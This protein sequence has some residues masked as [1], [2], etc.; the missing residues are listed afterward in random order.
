MKKTLFLLAFILPVCSVLVAQ[1]P[2]PVVPAASDQNYY[3]ILSTGNNN[4]ATV[5]QQNPDNW[6]RI[7]QPGSGN[8]ATVKQINY[9]TDVDNVIGKVYQEGNNNKARITQEYDGTLG[10][11]GVMEARI[12]QT[13]NGN[14][15][16][17]EQGPG[18]KTGE[19]LAVTNQSG[20]GN[21]GHQEQHG[22]YNNEF[23]LQEGNSNVGRQLQEN[24][25][26]GSNTVIL[27]PGS[28]NKAYQNQTGSGTALNAFTLQEGNGNKS[29]Q[30]QTGWVN[31]AVVNQQGNT[32]RARQDQAGPLNLARIRQ[33]TSANV[34]TQSQ[35]NTGGNHTAGYPAANVASI[36]QEGGN[37]NVAHQ[38]QTS[39]STPLPWEA[40]YGIIHQDGGGNKAWQTQDGGN[41]LGYV[42]QVGNGNVA[43]AS[44]SQ[45]ITP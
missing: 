23:I 28:G 21:A 2:T 26:M 32:S 45:T 8:S 17:Q 4:H 5:D 22:Y 13:G 10:P 31:L 29:T 12:N 3:L 6:A 37:G 41:N 34:A 19:M 9:N 40:N 18:N 30:N 33:N 42:I 38:V 20:N 11:L 44:Q 25:V 15:A 16:T 14:R 39:V 43:H 35:D 24:G 27:Q 1:T 7:L 36:L